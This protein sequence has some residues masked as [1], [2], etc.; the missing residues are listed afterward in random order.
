AN[1]QLLENKQTASAFN[2][3]KFY[4]KQKRYRAAVIYYNEVIRE[5]PGSVESEKAK[6]RIDQLRAKLGDAVMAAIPSENQKKPAETAKHEPAT[7]APSGG[8]GGALPP[9]ATNSSMT[10]PASF[11]ANHA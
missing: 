1:L 4:D 8:S 11:Y 10:P 2:V 7:R 9:P 3:A 5:Q 6:K